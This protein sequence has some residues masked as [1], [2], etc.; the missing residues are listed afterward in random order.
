MFCL[1]ARRVDLEPRSPR[2]GEPP[3]RARAAPWW[4]PLWPGLPLVQLPSPRSYTHPLPH[5]LPVPSPSS[6]QHP[7]PLRPPPPAAPAPVKGRRSGCTQK[8]AAG[9]GSGA[10]SHG[11]LP[12]SP[13][14]PQSPRIS[15]SLS[16][17]PGRCRLRFH[18]AC[19]FG[20]VFFSS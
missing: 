8:S 12:S 16:P 18:R 5:L 6:R 7:L 9:L 20:P 11:T 10:T 19:Q 17:R 14:A 1:S 2:R 3:A 4:S 13:D 15:S